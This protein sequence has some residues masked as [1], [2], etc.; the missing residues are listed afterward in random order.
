MN[1]TGFVIITLSLL[2]LIIIVWKAGGASA[3]GNLQRKTTWCDDYF[4]WPQ[5]FSKFKILVGR[6][7]NPIHRGPEGLSVVYEP[8]WLFGPTGLF[9][10]GKPVP[11]YFPEDDF[12]IIPAPANKAASHAIHQRVAYAINVSRRDAAKNQ[13]YVYLRQRNAQ[14]EDKLSQEKMHSEES[15]HFEDE[16][17]D[18]EI[19]RMKKAKEAV[20]IQVSTNKPGGNRPRW[21]CLTRETTT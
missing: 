2:T 15:I 16:K 21:A 5:T 10:R 3:L 4:G 11:H 8:T 14:L 6:E 7:G 12:E 13:E 18:K 20:S 17:H 19:E 9:G 1:I